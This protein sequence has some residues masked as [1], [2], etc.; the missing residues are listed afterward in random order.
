MKAIQANIRPEKSKRGSIRW[1]WGTII[2]FIGLALFGPMLANE[3]PLIV[4][5]ADQTYYPMWSD[6]NW[7]GICQEDDCQLT[8]TF[9]PYSPQT[10]DVANR[11]LSPVEGMSKQ[12]YL[13]TD[14]LGR[15][16]VSAIIHGARTA[17]FVSFF[18]AFL[19]FLFGGMYGLFMG[20]YSNNRI[21]YSPTKLLINILIIGAV[22][23]LMAWLRNMTSADML[24]IPMFL[25]LIGL[26]LGS[27]F[28]MLNRLAKRSIGTKRR[29]PLGELG[30]RLV[31]LI[32]A[33]PGLFIVLLV[34]QLTQQP[35][36]RQLIGLIAFLLAA[37]MARH[38]RAEVL[39]QRS[40]PS[41]LAALLHG[42]SDLVIWWHDIIPYMV[43]PLLVALALSMA[44][45]IL[46]EATLSFLGIGLPVEHVSWGT[47]IK[48]AQQAPEH[49]WLLVFPSICLIA[50]I[51]SLQ[52][53]G[54][55]VERS[56]RRQTT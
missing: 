51:W 3:N 14:A 46:L 17:I 12:H 5:T 29:L 9:I 8:H 44:G 56:L 25:L 53:L 21:Y 48:E 47:L 6:V 18:A 42:K 43:R 50:L 20:Y 11:N 32:E 15:D 1:A 13:G 16:V 28:F 24:S 39:R 35:G 23:Y 41:V 30:M 7:Q 33:L 31:D 40:K 10:I 38:A 52:R 4:R 36:V 49:W 54:R 27:T 45:A 26:L 2:L 34:M 22:I 19:A 37:T 55:A